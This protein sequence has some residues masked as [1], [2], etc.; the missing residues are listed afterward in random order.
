MIIYQI[1]ILKIPQH[2]QFWSICCHE[3]LY[4]AISVALY[5]FSIFPV[6]LYTFLLMKI[7][8]LYYF[9]TILHREKINT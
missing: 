7:F 5:N 6:N 4:T 3:K 1:N 8:S 2:L 9:H